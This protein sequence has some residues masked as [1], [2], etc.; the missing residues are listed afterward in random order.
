MALP[1]FRCRPDRVNGI[2]IDREICCFARVIPIARFHE[3]PPLFGIPVLL[4]RASFA[5]SLACGYQNGFYG[6]QTLHGVYPLAI[7]SARSIE[8][9]LF[10]K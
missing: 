3:K 2:P 7:A 9:L 10:A 4:R 1:S 8:I 5:R 6:L